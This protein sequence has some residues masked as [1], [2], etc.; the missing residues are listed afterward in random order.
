MP[1][2]LASHECELGGPKDSNRLHPVH[3]VNNFKFNFNGCDSLPLKA[4]CSCMEEMVRLVLPR[5]AHMCKWPA[6][7][8]MLD[9]QAEELSAVGLHSYT[10]HPGTCTTRTFTVCTKFSVPVRFSPIFLSPSRVRLTGLR[11]FASSH[12]PS[13]P[14]RQW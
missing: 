14:P 8:I 4:K 3:V 1:R 5:R 6:V 10:A 9:K 12:K 2:N 7:A 11:A 13:S